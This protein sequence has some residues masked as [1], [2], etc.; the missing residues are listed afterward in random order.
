V[1][2]EEEIKISK[3][4]RLINIITIDE[5]PRDWRLWR[6]FNRVLS[7]QNDLALRVYAALLERKKQTSSSDIAPLV[8]APL[9]SVQRALEDLHELGLVSRERLERGYLAFEYWSVETPILGVLRL[10][11]ETYFQEGYPKKDYG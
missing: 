10:I 3:I 4:D 8:D 6:V 11:P 9:Y 2:I 1:P 7:S 5:T